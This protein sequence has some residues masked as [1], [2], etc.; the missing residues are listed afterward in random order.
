MHG[1]ASS[2]HRWCVNLAIGS[3]LPHTISFAFLIFFK[4]ALG[5]IRTD[6]RN[7]IYTRMAMYLAISIFSKALLNAGDSP[8]TLPTA[9]R[10][11]VS[12]ELDNS[13]LLTRF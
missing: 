7:R 11:P 3:S 12:A 9:G 4:K 2:C 1:E 13:H 5:N 6:F 8:P 10:T